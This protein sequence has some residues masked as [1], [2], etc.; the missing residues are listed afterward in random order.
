MIPL[1]AALLLTSCGFAPVSET[2]GT[3]AVSEAQSQVT[4]MEEIPV[5]DYT[6]PAQL[7]N[8]LVD[9][10][11]YDADGTKRIGVK[12]SRLPESFTLVD[13]QSGETVYAGL[14]EDVTPD[15]EQG[16]YSAAAVLDTWTQPGTYYLK[17]DYIGQSYPFTITEGLYETTFQALYEEQLERCADGEMTTD[18]VIV[19]L[20]TCEWYPD[21]FP[22][23]DAD[24]TPD[25]FAALTKWVNLDKDADPAAGTEMRYA[26]ALAKFSYLYQKYDKQYATECLQRAS[27]VFDLTQSTLQSDADKFFALTELYR[28]TGLY[29]YRNQIA[30]YQT[31]FDN[32][33]NYLEERGYQYGVMT[34]LATRQEVDVELCSLFMGTLMDSGEEI[35][36]LYGEMTQPLNPRNNGADDLL[37][38]TRALVCAN[39]VM[40]NYQYSRGLETFLHYLRGANL[41]STDFYAER[42]PGQEYLLYYAQL[43]AGGI[44]E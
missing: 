24:G 40:N 44:T 38:H 43:A 20:Q 15:A 1:T 32:H 5:V 9:L 27:T 7:P 36:E 16:L 21:L 19:L 23:E 41:E 33:S 31:Y 35:G 2:A 37:Q 8:I 29:T 10:E 14:L 39:Y 30:D 25:V 28:A 22:D 42:E 4:A 6:V 17:C 34:Y 11:G 13:A 12:G 3:G 18:E 26:A